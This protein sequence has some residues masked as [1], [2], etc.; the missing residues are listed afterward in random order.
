[1]FVFS[2]C[3]HKYAVMRYRAISDQAFVLPCD[4]LPEDPVSIFNHSCHNGSRVQWLW[5]SSDGKTQR[6]PNHKTVNPTDCGDVLWFN[7]IRVQD[8]GTYICENRFVTEIEIP[9]VIF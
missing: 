7:P 8:S 5:Q 3:L 9:S 6:F 4:L 1:M 2:G